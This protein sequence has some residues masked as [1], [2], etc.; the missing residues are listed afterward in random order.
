MTVQNTRPML[1]A[2]DTEEII[3]LQAGVETQLAT[4]IRTEREY[5]KEQLYAAHTG[6]YQ[7]NDGDMLDV[8]R[9]T[10]AKYRALLARIESARGKLAR[11]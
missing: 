1:V 8:T 3:M 11:Q 7:W 6:H 5:V 9:E 4:L 10:I 2:L